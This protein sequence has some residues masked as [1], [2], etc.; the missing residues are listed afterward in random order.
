MHMAVLMLGASIV[1]SWVLTA[2]FARTV[3]HRVSGF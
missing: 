3:I 2:L 1:G